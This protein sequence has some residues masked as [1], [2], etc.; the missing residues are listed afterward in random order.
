MIISTCEEMNIITFVE[1]IIP[2]FEEMIIFIFWGNDHSRVG[3]IIPMPF[4]SLLF[5][6]VCTFAFHRSSRAHLK[7]WTQWLQIS[8]CANMNLKLAYI[9]PINDHFHLRNDHSHF[10]EMIIPT[11]QE[12]IISSAFKSN[13]NSKVLSLANFLSKSK[14]P[15]LSLFIWSFPLEFLKQDVPEKWLR[16]SF[17][18][19]K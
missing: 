18:E 13:V 1:M 15:Q 3:M 16:L 17:S 9:W 11:F 8:K 5:K 2:T 6:K 19:L 4:I 14:Q 10:E 7:V 12:M